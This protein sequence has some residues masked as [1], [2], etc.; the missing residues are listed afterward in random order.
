[1]KRL[2]FILVSLY[3]GIWAAQAVDIPP[4][5]PWP[6]KVVW[7]GEEFHTYEPSVSLKGNKSFIG[8]KLLA[9]YSLRDNPSS[10]RTLSIN[11]VENLPG[12][13]MN[14]DEA[15]TLRV[16]SEGIQIEAVTAEVDVHLRIGHTGRQQGS[17]RPDLFT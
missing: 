10:R 15:Y 11:I 8:R 1:M 4:L 17:R 5:L 2:L 14:Q 12:I 9:D 7:T 16:S 6:Q 13:P 3:A